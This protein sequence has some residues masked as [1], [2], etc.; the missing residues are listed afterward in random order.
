MEQLQLPGLESVHTI[1]KQKKEAQEAIQGTKVI[2]SS[3]ARNFLEDDARMMTGVVVKDVG[4]KG[5][6]N[7]DRSSII[8]I[9]HLS[10]IV[11]NKDKK[12]KG[13]G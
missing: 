9:P 1:M 12:N 13:K 10:D 2:S 3:G 6:L 8:Q 5:H 11:P 4:N 7:I